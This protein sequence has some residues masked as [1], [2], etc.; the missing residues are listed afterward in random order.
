M[1]KLDRLNIT[2]D[3]LLQFLRALNKH[4]LAGMPCSCLTH[5]RSTVETCDSSVV[6]PLGW[7][8]FRLAEKWLQLWQHK[9]GFR[10]RDQ[11]YIPIG[12]TSL[13]CKCLERIKLDLLFPYLINNKT[14]T[15]A[16]Q[17]FIGNRWCLM[18][19]LLFC[20]ERNPLKEEDKTV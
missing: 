20:D 12:F 8:R 13:V 9:A 11:N 18:N 7:E 6:H 10:R 19:R 3:E 1:A 4:K 14:M 16:Q 17:D 2:E 15:Y 5:G